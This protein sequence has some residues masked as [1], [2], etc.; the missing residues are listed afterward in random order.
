MG[1]KV[2]TA[3][4]LEQY[5]KDLPRLPDGRIDFRDATDMPVLSCFVE[6]QGRLLLLKRS[7]KVRSYQGKWCVVAGVIDQPKPLEELVHIELRAE[8]GVKPEDVA[9]I[10]IGEA[11]AFTDERLGKRWIVHPLFVRLKGTPRIE[12][13]W[14][15]TDFE[16]IRPEELGKYDTVPMLEES[17]RRA[18]KAAL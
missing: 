4:L 17:M 8:L 9:S 14:E 3:A 2:D 12:I 1:T 16:W 10:A 13:D 18:I 11:Y 15:H 6:C 7:A 5:G